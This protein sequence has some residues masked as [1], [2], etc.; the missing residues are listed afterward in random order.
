MDGF[1]IP[2]PL[3]SYLLDEVY[4]PGRRSNGRNILQDVQPHWRPSCQSTGSIYYVGCGS[5]MVILYHPV[6]DYLHV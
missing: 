4:S 3:E 2:F 1:V 5:I 6:N